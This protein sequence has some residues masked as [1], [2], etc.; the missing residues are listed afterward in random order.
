MTSPTFLG[1][2]VVNLAMLVID[3]LTAWLLLTT[4]LVELTETEA[5]TSVDGIADV[6]SE[7]FEE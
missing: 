3:E 5:E 1:W 7:G 2:A 4:P 6:L